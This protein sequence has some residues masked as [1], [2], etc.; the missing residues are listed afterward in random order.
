MD[1][2]HHAERAGRAGHAEGAERGWWMQE[3]EAA[4]FEAFR[5][6][7]EDDGIQKVWHNYS[8]DRHVFQRM[9]G[10]PKPSCMH[11]AIF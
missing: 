9:V 3:E 2:S 11:A 4:I 1:A 10:S 5:P 8:F 6:F 7:F